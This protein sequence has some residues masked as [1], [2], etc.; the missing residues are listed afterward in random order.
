[1][2]RIIA[3][4]SGGRRI[5]MPPG[6]RTRPTTDRVREALFSA[7]TAWAGTSDRPPAEALQGLAFCDLFAG[8]G[9]VGLEAASRG[10]D[11]VLLVEVDART[12][13]VAADNLRVVG[14][15][16]QIRTGR[17]EQLTSQPAVAPFD[18]V[19]ADPPYELESGRV[20][21]I[22]ACLPQNGW[23][24]DDGLV[25]VERSKRSAA[26]A[27]PLGYTDV[28]TRTYGETQLVFCGR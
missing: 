8:S 9:A 7:L 20:E 28:W 19:Y 12:A 24:A 18:I 27:P 15:R 5:R 22:L 6:G 16:A 14:L 3:G 13:Q 10:A 2:S 11:P 21:A 1:M 17:V 25:V 26:L 4:S 23:V